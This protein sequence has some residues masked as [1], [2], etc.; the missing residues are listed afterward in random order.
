MKK[1]WK[2]LGIVTSVVSPWF[3]FLGKPYVVSTR[4]P[5]LET[6]NLT[7]PPRFP[8]LETWE[9]PHKW[10]P[11]VSTPENSQPDNSTTFP[12]IGI[13]GETSQG[14]STGFRTSKLST[15]GFHLDP[16]HG[17]LMDTYVGAV[18]FSHA[19]TM[20][21]KRHFQRNYYF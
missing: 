10:F 18:F 9:K 12:C 1:C 13:C 8:A 6:V 2:A 21:S 11:R 14:V 15:S 16:L 4:F 5:D 7:I 17:Q 3:Q 20:F 19:S